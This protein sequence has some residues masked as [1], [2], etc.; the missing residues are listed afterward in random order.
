M[1]I[2]KW[3]AFLPAFYREWFPEGLSLGRLF[4]SPGSA[5]SGY[6]PSMDVYTDEGDVIVKM[7][8]P[9][10]T[11]DDVDVSL[12]DS[13]L[14]IS[15]KHK[16]EERVEEENYLRRERYTGSFARTVPLPGEVKEEDIA[17]NLKDGILEV[18]IKGAAA[19]SEIAGKKKIPIA[20]D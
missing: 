14:T 17:A 2:V 20:A 6:I 19:E 4:D 16:H 11:S 1:A 12:E 10:F 9:E 3:D 8:L 15:G 7:E 5:A 13:C 18:R